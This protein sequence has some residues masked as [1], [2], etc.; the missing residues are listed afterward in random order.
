ME[1]APIASGEFRDALETAALEDQPWIGVAPVIT[2]VCADFRTP[3]EAFADQPPAGERGSRYVY[4]EAGAAAQ[5]VQ[6]QAAAEGLGCVLVAGFDDESTTKVL[7]LRPPIEPVLYL[8]IGWP[9][10]G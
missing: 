8:C 10:D 3:M 9:G 1:L 4:I 6:L 2:A 7:K 5:N